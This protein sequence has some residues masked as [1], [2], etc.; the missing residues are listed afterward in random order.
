MGDP[1]DE[2]GGRDVAAIYAEAAAGYDRSTERLSRWLGFSEARYRQLAVEALELGP[3]DTVVEI[4]CGTGLNHPA[5]QEKIGPA[6]R[7]IGGDLTREMLDRAEHQARERGWRNVELVHSDALAFRFPG[8][9]DG[10]LST[11]VLSF[12]PDCRPVI[13]AGAAALAPGRRWAITDQKLPRFG[14]RITS[15]AFVALTGKRYGITTEMM[16]S[17]RWEAAREALG[18]HLEDIRWTERYFGFVFVASGTA[19]DP[20]NHLP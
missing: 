6:G 9:V 18:G 7:I 16:M 3:G 10:V 4:G 20:R 12:L 5:I 8:D 1:R 2:S 13:E 19:P 11:F 15:A 17:R 14:Q